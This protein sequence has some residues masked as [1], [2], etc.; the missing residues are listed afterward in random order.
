MKR[1]EFLKKAGV[2]LATGFLVSRGWVRAQGQATL[3][4]SLGGGVGEG[5][6]WMRA[7]LAEF[8]RRTGIRAEVFEAPTDTDAQLALYQ[9]YWA[10][11]SPDIDVYM[12]DV[13]WPGIIAPHALDLKQYFTEAELREFFPRIVQNNTIRGKLTSIPFFTDAGL[14]YYRTD[15]LQ[16]Y[17]YRNPPRTWAELSQMAQRVMDE[18]RKAGNR[19]FWGFVFQGKPYEGLTCDALEWIYSFGGGRIVESDGTISVNNG[20]AALA[21]N[22]V[23]RFVGTIAPQGVTSYAEEEARNVWQQGNAL[24]MRNWPYA[25]ALGQADNSPIRGKFG[26]TVL[27][28]GAGDAPNAATLGGWQLMVSAYSRYPKEA[29]DLVRFL[30]STESQKDFALNLSWLPTRPALYNDRDVLAKTPWFKDLLPVFQNAVSRPS[31]VA[32]AR[33][34]QVSEAIWTEVHSALTGRKT[35]EA[36]VR[37]LEA[38]LRRILR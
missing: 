10:G 36:A 33:Y 3:R 7:R 15:L 23:R 13:I 19:D 32:G 16:K 11:R 4:V 8:T 1:R 26:V 30:T 29:A 37:D 31:D 28:K 6:R 2:G 34:N 25:Y 20:K 17:G 12:V 9:Q 24:F 22:T 38:R 21:L 27:P 14:L 18:E 35:G 5:P